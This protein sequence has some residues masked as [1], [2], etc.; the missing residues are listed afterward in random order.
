FTAAQGLGNNDVRGMMEDPDGNLWFALGGGGV[1]R[2]DGRFITGFTVRDGL[3]S[4][5]VRCVTRDLQGKIWFGTYLGGVSRFDGNTFTTFSTAHGLANNKVWAVMC[6]TSGYL[7][8]GTVGGGVSRF[9]GRSFTTFDTSH[10]LIHNNVR[11]LYQDRTGHIWIGTEGGLSKFD[12]ER[13]TN[14]TTA[15]GLTHNSVHSIQQDRRGNMWFGTYNGGVSRYDGKHF[16][17]YTRRQGLADNIVRDIVEDRMGNLWFCTEGGGVSL[18]TGEGVMSYTTEQGLP[19]HIIRGIYEDAQGRIWL[20]TNAGG[21]TIYDGKTFTSWSRAQGLP[22]NR[23]HVVVGDRAGNVWLGTDSGAVY[24]DGSNMSVI[25]VANGLPDIHVRCIYEDHEG[26]MWFGTEDGGVAIYDGKKFLT[27]TTAEGLP[28]NDVRGIVQD[29][30]GNF[31]LATHGGGI[32]RFDGRTFLNFSKEQGLANDFVFSIH[33]DSGGNIWAGTGNGGVSIIRREKIQKLQAGDHT[34]PVFQDFT[35]RE[36][37]AN[38]VVYDVTEDQAGNIFIGT[39]L[40]LTLVRKGLSGIAGSIPPERIEYYNTRTGYPIKDANTQAMYVDRNGVLWMG[41]GEKLV[42]FN[43]AAINRNALPAR[44]QVENVQVNNE[45]ISWYSLLHSKKSVT[46]SPRAEVVAEEALT[47]ITAGD[48][49]RDSMVRKFSRISFDSIR[50]FYPLPVNLQLPYRFNTVSIGYNALEPAR[51]GLVS[52]Q[53]MLDGYH[54]EWSPVTGRTTAEFGNLD[55]GTYTFRVRART[56]GRT[57]SEPSEYRFEVLPPVHRTWWFLSFATLL[58]L[59]IIFLAAHFRIRMIR[60]KEQQKMLHEK[61]LLEMEARALRAQMNPHFIFNCLNSIKALIQ[62]HDEQGSISYLTTFSKLIRTLFQNSDKRQITLYDELETCRL[63]TRLE[64]MR[65]NGK[66]HYHFEVDPLADLKSI[67]VPALIIQPFIENAIW[68]GIVPK[69]TPGTVRVSVESTGTSVIC[70]VDDDG[71]GRDRSRINRPVTPV[72]HESK[73]VHLS[74]ARMDLEKI[75]NDSNAGIR[76]ID[77]F[78]GDQACGTLVELHFDIDG[79]EITPDNKRSSFVKQ[80]FRVR[81]SVKMNGNK[82]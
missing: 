45:K 71:I 28:S 15:D 9:D 67:M 4:N 37:L 33:R 1:A 69:D 10:G 76:I 82:G 54:D 66:L 55:P 53:Y 49:L 72:I 20:G 52:Y 29:D 65:L 23:V 30:A 31:W 40:G 51:A 25:S 16:T 8:F 58:L 75:L 64:A 74:Q 63:Y 42:R 18:Y 36:G 70:R 34:A 79:N 7:W 81:K 43:D 14:Y 73:G 48:K 38:D 21:L 77:K 62:N 5:E 39:N 2:Y 60:R 19:D 50:K 22:H 35:S 47:G 17:S 68:H 44:I 57:W 46:N 6:D 26:R 59:G 56:P 78:E 13:F 32:S 3:G 12:G 27:Y 80:L 11:S 41:T 61:E 24:I